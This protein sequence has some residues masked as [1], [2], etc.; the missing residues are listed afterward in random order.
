MTGPDAIDAPKLRLP[1]WSFTI[2]WMML[3]ADTPMTSRYDP[4]TVSSR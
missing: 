1:R 2:W 3:G 4:P